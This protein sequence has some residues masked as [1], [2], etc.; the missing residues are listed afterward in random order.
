MSSIFLTGHLGFVGSALLPKLQKLGYDVVTDMRYLKSKRWDVIIHLAARTSI[1]LEFDPRI[2]YDN[3]I[4]TEQILTLPSRCI[5]ASS[6][7]AKYN[8]NPYATSKI[9]AEHLGE[10]H[11]NAVGLRFHNIY[12]PGANRGIV[13]FLMDQPDGAKVA[14]RGDLLIRDYIF[15]DCV[16]NE[17][18]ESLNYEPGV[19]DVGSGVGTQTMDLVNLYQK[20][21]GKSFNIY[22]E[23]A[24]AH[25]P[26]EMV[27]NR[28]VPHISLEEGLTKTINHK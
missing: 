5:Y 14:I 27:S 22:V 24:G 23:E 12:G 13:K 11:G 18:V 19:Y 20:L 17:I 1:A 3:I 2:Y 28:I 10:K 26:K 9:W 15:I 8:T 6:C 25:E 16:V 4:L 7:S 21:C